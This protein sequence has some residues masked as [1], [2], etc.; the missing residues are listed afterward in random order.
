MYSYNSYHKI[1]V[2]LGVVIWAVFHFSQR[3]EEGLYYDN[4][5]IKQTGGTKNSLNEGV[6]TWFH[7]D[8]TVQLQGEFIHGNKIGRAHV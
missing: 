1:V 8:G 3:N 2:V 6:W 5:Q 4:G 7:S